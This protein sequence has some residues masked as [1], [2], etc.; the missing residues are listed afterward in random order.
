MEKMYGF[1]IK[2]TLGEGSFS[3][4]KKAQC[5]KTKKSYAIKLVENPFKNT[6][7][8]RLL[9][10]EI[11]MLKALIAIQGNIFTTKIYDILLPPNIF[12]HDT[13]RPVAE[14]L[15]QDEPIESS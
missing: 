15:D 7:H 2:K 5:L 10:R 1:K 12:V 8:A 11:R 6:Q 9:L 14:H 13:P 4:V 3:I